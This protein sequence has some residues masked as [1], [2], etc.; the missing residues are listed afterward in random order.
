MNPAL[1]G[2]LPFVAASENGCVLCVVCFGALLRVY[3]N[4]CELR[5]VVQCYWNT[6]LFLL[7]VLLFNTR[8]IPGSIVFI[9]ELYTNE[10]FIYLFPLLCVVSCIGPVS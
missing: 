7:L 4:C 3:T 1:P 2:I 8:Y 5:V 10:V 6:F 9:V